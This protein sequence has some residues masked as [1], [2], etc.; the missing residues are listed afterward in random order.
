MTDY[1]KLNEQFVPF[2]A[3]ASLSLEVDQTN[4]DAQ[5]RASKF[6]S[7]ASKIGSQLSFVHSDLSALS[8]EILEEAATIAPQFENYLKQIIKKKHISYTL[9]SKKH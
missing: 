5:M 4:D 7:I 1:E 9:K 6:G 8:T 2:G 3:Y